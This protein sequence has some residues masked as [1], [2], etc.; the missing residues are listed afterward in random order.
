[1]GKDSERHGPPEDHGNPGEHGNPDPFLVAVRGA[2]RPL[3]DARRAGEMAAYMRNRFP[4]LGIQTPARRHATMPIIR[5]WSG[6]PLAAAA[7]LWRAPERE[8]Q[9]VGCDLL[10]RHAERLRAADLDDVLSLVAA[11]SW[12]DTVDALARVV[13]HLVRR[14]RR[15]AARMDTLVA[16]PDIWRRR[17]ALL[18]QLGWRE[19]T[20]VPRLFDH[21]LRR[22]GDEDFFI[23]KAIG[24]ALR[25]FAKHDP[26]GVTRF[27]DQNAGR[28]SALTRREA[29]KHLGL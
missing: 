17:V 23:R 21:C 16:D 5:G 11:K 27:I 14:N 22:A 7:A 6:P 2:L 19:E 25:D 24:W 4:F 13:G 1:M 26:G 28:L 10:L 3:A 15:L 9:Y 18:H 12:W 8:Y 20:D 29:A